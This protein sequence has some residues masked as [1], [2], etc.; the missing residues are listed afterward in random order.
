MIEEIKCDAIDVLDE[1]RKSLVGMFYARYSQEDR[2]YHDV[3]QIIGREDG[4]YLCRHW[5]LTG[6]LEDCSY[7]R[8][9]YGNTE[10]YGN[11]FVI[12]SSIII[13]DAINNDIDEREFIFFDTIENFSEFCSYIARQRAKGARRYCSGRKY[14]EDAE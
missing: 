1:P 3:G 9:T 14:T 5:F 7:G 10:G 6:D 2:D 11:V 4:F 8:V 12:P 13:Q